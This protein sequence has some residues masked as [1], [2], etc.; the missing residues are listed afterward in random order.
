MRSRQR[1]TATVVAI[2]GALMLSTGC[3]GRNVRGPF[4]TQFLDSETKQPI[5]GVVFLAVWHTAV[6]NPVSGPSEPFY[7]AREVVSGPDGRVD[8][9]RL[10][11]P[12]FKLGL[13]VRFYNFAPGGF[14]TERVQVTPAGG[15]RYVDTTI[16]LLRR[17]ER[18]EERLKNIP[19]LPSVPDEKMPRFIAILDQERVALG[20]SEYYPKGH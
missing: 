17:L 10:S 3:G 7:E 14:A 16:T 12:V 9:P 1:K 19:S 6:P 8:V 20:L 13:D 11:G 5:P 15:R 18:R 2:V 4:R